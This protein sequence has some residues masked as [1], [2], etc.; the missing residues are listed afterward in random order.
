MAG[1]RITGE[2]REAMAKQ[3]LELYLT[4]MTIREVSQRLGCSY[5]KAHALITK[6]AGPDV[7]RRR[8]TRTTTERK[9]E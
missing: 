2:P 3:A 4:P 5:G 7:F 9:T 8:G 1:E 6:A